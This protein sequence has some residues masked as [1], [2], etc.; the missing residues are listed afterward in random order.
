MDDSLIKF[1]IGKAD[2]VRV[3]GSYIQLSKKGKNFVGVCPFHADN[4]PSLYVSPEKKVYKCFSC[5]HSG[6]AITFV[7]DKEKISFQSAMKKVAEIC[8]FDDPR[9]HDEYINKNVE[10]QFENLLNCI[11]DLNAAYNFALKSVSSN[12]AK[13]YL[14]KRKIDDNKIN[15]FQIGYCPDDGTRTIEFLTGKGYSLKDINEIGVLKSVGNQHVDANK[16]RVIFPLWNEDGK[17]IGFSA[18]CI[19]KKD[20]EPKY[21]NTGETKL[22]TKSKVLYNYFRAKETCKHDKFIYVCEGFMDAIAIDTLGKSAVALMGTALTKEQILMLKKLYVEIRLCLDN[23]E[24]GRIAT[25][26]SI[27]L[28]KKAKVP[29][30]IVTGI[31]TYKDCDEI[32]FN[33][34]AEALEKYI[35]T[36]SNEFDFELEILNKE[37]FNLNTV[38]KERKG[39]EMISYLASIQDNSLSFLSFLEKFCKIFGYSKDVVLEKM[40]TAK[41]YKAVEIVPNKKDEV[42]VTPTKKEI[43]SDKDFRDGETI[44][45]LTYVKRNYPDLY[46][47]ELYLVTLVLFKK[48]LVMSVFKNEPLFIDEFRNTYN[49]ALSKNISFSTIQEFGRFVVSNDVSILEPFKNCFRAD[50]NKKKKDFSLTFAIVKSEKESSLKDKIEGHKDLL[51]QIKKDQLDYYNFKT[52][53]NDISYLK[54]IMGKNKEKI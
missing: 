17:V 24:P 2:I 38:E 48:D 7:R 13:E 44:N 5:G 47:F 4:N 16:G 41:P 27:D 18:R 11:N 37:I 36:L 33:Q 25:R 12:K 50:E 54:T 26:R 45:S 20:D 19:E 35:S 3:I 46:N 52:C 21:V 9:L 29:F 32:L 30:R 34:G 42:V 15:K 14:E 31:S 51:K 22:F 28:L 6:N 1:I 39:Q 10:P 43:V 8:G 49:F 40:K 23:D 53:P